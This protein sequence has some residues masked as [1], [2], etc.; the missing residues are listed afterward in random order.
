MIALL[1]SSS[2][3][4]DEFCAQQV[5]I[6]YDINYFGIVMQM[7]IREPQVVERMKE[8]FPYNDCYQGVCAAY[9]NGETEE[10]VVNFTNRMSNGYRS[11]GSAGKYT[12]VGTDNG[13][14]LAVDNGKEQDSFLFRGC[15]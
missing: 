13:T 14:W 6:R 4:A 12:T 15:Y 9:Y 10:Y 2:L 11:L 3:M 7:R 5:G 8:L 1:A